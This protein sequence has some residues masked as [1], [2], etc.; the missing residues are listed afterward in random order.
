MTSPELETMNS[1]LT[2]KVISTQAA[3]QVPVATYARLIAS[4]E[5]E[6]GYPAEAWIDR[7]NALN[8]TALAPTQA[9]D[10][11]V[12]QLPGIAKTISCMQVRIADAKDRYSDR[13]M[14]HVEYITGGWSG[15]EDL[16]GAMLRQFW[17]RH[18]HSRWERGGYYVFEVPDHFLSEPSKD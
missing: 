3:E 14:K 5:A 16:I 12:N 1:S 7:F 13:P 10:F 11:L 2:D 15:A 8:L 4:Y 9:A 6:E 18:F 17:I